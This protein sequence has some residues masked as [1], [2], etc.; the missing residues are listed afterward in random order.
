MPILNAKNNMFTIWF[1]PNFFYPSI[2]KKWDP[3]IRR[4]KLPYE[5][6][7]DFYNA[8]IQ[9]VTF[10]E[11]D[12][13][14]P[15]QQQSQFEIG[16]KGGKE[17]EPILD[18]NLDITIKLSEGFITY[19]I[20]FEQIEE[21]LRYDNEEN[22][23]FWPTMYVSFLDH[24]GFELVVFEFNKIVPRKLSSFD[25]N[26]STTAADFNTFT[27]GI[28][29]N[30]YNIKRRIDDNNYDVNNFSTVIPTMPPQ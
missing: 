29:Y 16:Y 6:I 27:L 3:I 4:M 24:H 9:S 11:V 13:N 10:P 8:N 30:R 2:V 21:Y 17:L 19:W 7:E 12:L 28:R 26:Y 1:P 18:R 22:D 14:I 20:I 15:T 25:V 23:V 5:T